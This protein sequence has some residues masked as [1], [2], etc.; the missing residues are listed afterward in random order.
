M[1]MCCEVYALKIENVFTSDMP[2]LCMTQIVCDLKFDIIR[3]WTAAV[4]VYEDKGYRMTE[5][6]TGATGP[7]IV[8]SKKYRSRRRIKNEKQ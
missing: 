3:D 4:R 7:T 5:F 2:E 8:M 6:Y 1:V